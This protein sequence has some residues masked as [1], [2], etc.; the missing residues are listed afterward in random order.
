[1]TKITLAIWWC[2]TKGKQFKVKDILNDEERQMLVN[3]DEGFYIYPT[4]R[5]SPAYLD[6]RNKDAFAMIR[7]LGF[8]SLFISMSA[9]ETK[10]PEL[11][12][13]LGKNV[14]KK[15][16]SNEEIE[17]MNWDTKCRLLNEDSATVVRYFDQRFLQ[18]FYLVVI[19]SHT[20]ISELTDH[21][22]RYEFAEI[23]TWF[24][25]YGLAL[26]AEINLDKLPIE[27]DMTEEEYII[28]VWISLVR[29]KLFLKC[30]PCE[31]RVNNYMKNCLEIWRANHDIQ[32]ALSPYAMIQYMSYS[33]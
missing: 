27:L 31:I 10:W 7:Q 17:S 13:A 22:M 28:A 11:L 16:N 3:L 9:A 32:P 19:I 26:D 20:P 5:N 33:S 2:K 25:Q 18:V 8:P 23:G 1:M 15:I 24:N 12:R 29:P 6:K 21:F 30:R 4:L 14:D